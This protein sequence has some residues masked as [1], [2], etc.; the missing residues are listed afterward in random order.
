MKP[1]SPSAD[2][3]TRPS[4]LLWT[5]GVATVYFAVVW[6]TSS[7]LVADAQGALKDKLPQ[8]VGVVLLPGL[9]LLLSLPMKLIASDLFAHARPALLWSLWIFNGVLWGMFVA[10]GIQ[11]LWRRKQRSEAEEKE[12]TKPS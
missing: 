4:F 1:D 2:A 12:L 6:T 3:K 11:W 10:C 7:L 8:F 5:A 9:L